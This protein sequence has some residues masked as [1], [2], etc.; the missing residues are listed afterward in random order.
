MEAGTD[1]RAFTEWRQ[2]MWKGRDRN[3]LRR[4]CLYTVWACQ[5]WRLFVLHRWVLATLPSASALVVTDPHSSYCSAVISWVSLVLVWLI[6][7]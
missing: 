4:C 7:R 6:L 2:E 5:Q 1:G 3:M